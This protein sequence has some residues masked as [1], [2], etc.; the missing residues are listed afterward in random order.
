MQLPVIYQDPYRIAADT[1]I[2]PQI[3]PTGPGVCASVNSM[4]ITAAEPVIVD[5]GCAVNRARWTEQ[6]FS[7]VDPADVRWV[8]VS[9]AD[10]DHIGNVDVVLEECPNATLITT[11]WGVI[12]T[13][14]DGVP[15]LQRMRWINHGES[16]DAGDRT[17]QAV[18]PPTWDAANTRG[19]YDPTTGVYWGAD[20]FAS[21][22]THPVTNVAELDHDF[23]AESFLYE[24][25]SA[26]GWHALLDP[27]KFD[28]QV[29]QTAYL[30]PSVVASA[31]GPVLTGEYV[32]E[33]FDMTRQLVR[34]APVE[35]PGQPLLELMIA[36]VAAVPV[37][38][39][40]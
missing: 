16:F 6:V 8:F 36:A 3:V 39:A 28:A 27:D 17:L 2:I 30:S 33:A 32:G 10:R 1:W 9:H 12:Y 24:G 15:S 20:S 40:A 7:I 11:Y 37:P 34:M 21:K 14:A 35:Q 23:W 22:L 25:R 18:C 19:L 31:H 4:V 13:L 29:A 26:V 38:E 5:T